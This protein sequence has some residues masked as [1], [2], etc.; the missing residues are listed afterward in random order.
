MILAG[1][2]IGYMAAFAMWHGRFAVVPLL[3]IVAVA[4]VHVGAVLAFGVPTPFVCLANAKRAFHV[5]DGAAFAASSSASLSR[6]RCEMTECGRCGNEMR[7]RLATR[8]EPYVYVLSGLQNIG[9]FGIRV[10]RCTSCN[11]ERPRIPRLPEL[12]VEIANLLVHKASK[13]TGH[14]V[15]F[16]RKQAGFP[17]NKF[18]ALIGISASY[19]SRIENGKVARFRDIIDRMSRLLSTSVNS[20]QDAKERLLRVADE[21]LRQKRAPARE[22]ILFKMDRTWKMATRLKRST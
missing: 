12:H 14:E 2:A 22:Q 10:W 11:Y 16:L 1:M 9:L 7:E 15:R 6:V 21:R 20:G 18:A 13:L 5:P 3:L 17:G 8:K 4:L 19:L